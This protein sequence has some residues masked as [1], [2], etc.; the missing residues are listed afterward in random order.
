[1]GLCALDAYSQDDGKVRRDSTVNVADSLGLNEATVVA[2]SPIAKGTLFRYDAAQAANTIS[3]LGEPDVLR[4]ISSFP[5]VSTGIEGTLGLFVRGGDCASNGVFYDDV[6][7][8]ATSHVMGFVSV[9]PPEMVDNVTFYKGG[10]PA[11]K[12]NVSSSLLDVGLKKQYGEPYSGK[13]YVSPYM[14]GIYNSI[15]V[16]RDRATLQVSGRTTVIPYVIDWFNDTYTQVDVDVYDINAKLDVR[17]SDSNTLNMMFFHTNDCF[18]YTDVGIKRTVQKWNETIFKTGWNCRLS[19]FVS[20]NTNVYYNSSES[21]Q[22]DIGFNFYDGTFFSM[23]QL[24]PKLTKRCFKTVMNWTPTHNLSFNCGY[25]VQKQEYYV[26][27]ERKHKYNGDK[28]EHTRYDNKLNIAF[29]EL[30]YSL[31]DLTDV[32]VGV[33]NVNQ[34]SGGDSFSY[35]DV[36]VLNHWYICRNL[37]IEL[38]YDYLHQHY[39]VLEGLPTGWSLNIKVPSDKKYDAESTSQYYGGFFWRKSFSAVETNLTIGGY[40]RKMDGLLS[41][42]DGKN[43]FGFSTYSWQQEVDRGRGTSYGVECALSAKSERFMSS[44]SYTW[45]KTDRTYP[46]INNGVTFPFK[47]DRRHILNYQGSY[48]FAKKQRDA[49]TVT[50]SLG[51]AVTYTSG[52]RLTLPVGTYKGYA[53]PYWERV[54]GWYFTST[55]LQQVYDRQEMSDKNAIS[56]KPYFR[57]DVSYTMTRKSKKYTKELAFS[58]FNV[59]NVHNPYTI[60]REDGKWKQLSLIPIMPSVRWSIS[61]GNKD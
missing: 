32:R 46:N 23:L 18:D 25:S 49:K 52:N 17:I 20:L 47:F 48:M 57:T 4:H 61:W 26:D 31:D 34:H 13:F 43:A 5:G 24:E 45:S 41:Y 36:H 29:A 58:I 35:P 56:T 28:Y 40:Y 16:V 44:L 11:S 60:F 21:R 8:Y 42:I 14:I 15:P 59:F 10:I 19:D 2:L 54:K 3:V 53:P 33:R 6:P 51:C 37:G 12:G 27:S 9:F 50:H 38:T 55:F 7:V 39:H 22:T 1:L 30:S